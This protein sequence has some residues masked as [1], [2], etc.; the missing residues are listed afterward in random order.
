MSR[1]LEAVRRGYAYVQMNERGHFFSEGEYDILGA[2]L[3]DGE[4]ALSWIA[5]Q[6]WSNGTARFDEMAA[7]MEW[8]MK[9]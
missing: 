1:E 5:A 7:R 8:L 6:T 3:T 2:P 4:D 9:A